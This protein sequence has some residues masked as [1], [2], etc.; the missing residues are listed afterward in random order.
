LL[1]PHLQ[2]T[3][4]REPSKSDFGVI[5][6]FRPQGDAKKGDAKKGLMGSLAAKR[7][8]QTG[9]SVISPAADV[10]IECIEVPRGMQLT[11]PE[12]VTALN[13]ASCQKLLER[14]IRA[15]R[16]LPERDELPV[17]EPVGQAVGRPSTRAPATEVEGG[18]DGAAALGGR[19]KPVQRWGEGNGGGSD[20]EAGG[21]NEGGSAAAHEWNESARGEKNGTGWGGGTGWGDGGNVGGREEPAQERMGNDGG[22][23]WGAARWG[24]EGER[25]AA[26]K[27]DTGREEEIG[28]RDSGQ[29]RNETEDPREGTGWGNEFSGSSGDGVGSAWGAVGGNRGED[30]GDQFTKIRESETERTEACQG[31]TGWG[32]GIDGNDERDFGKETGD[33]LGSK[34]GSAHEMGPQVR[35]SPETQEVEGGEGLKTTHKGG[36][37]SKQKERP[38]DPVPPFD[39]QVVCIWSSA[40]DTWRKV[41]HLKPKEALE[42]EVG[43][44]I[45]RL[46]EAG[47]YVVANRQPSLH[48]HSL[49]AFQ[50][51]L[52]DGQTIG[53]PPQ[54]CL[55]FNAD[56]DGDEVRMIEFKMAQLLL[57]RISIRGSYS[58]SS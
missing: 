31:G 41:G 9:R 42:L 24:K 32:D 58:T 8:D 4:R 30:E 53:L 11:K 48:R 2:A 57:F 7:G 6:F 1:P 3:A 43:D 49:L 23:G 28:T 56:F 17:N 51:K 54:V 46:L 52:T 26:P 12:R 5:D 33:V 45:E 16:G 21:G 36:D 38:N 34:K 35:E 15:A 14:S 18:F 44:I 40:K 10:S 39:G 47:D 29:E 22:N 13:L 25:E 50:V 19:D 27:E 37:P 20:W 55:P